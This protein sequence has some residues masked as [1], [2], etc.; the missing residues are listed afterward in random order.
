MSASI[1][2]YSKPQDCSSSTKPLDASK[3][4]MLLITQ[5]IKPVT[6]TGGLPLYTCDKPRGYRY[7]CGGLAGWKFGG[8]WFEIGL[9]VDAGANAVI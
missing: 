5:W 6:R 1:A 9:E 7:D 3:L 4:R 8:W 2:T